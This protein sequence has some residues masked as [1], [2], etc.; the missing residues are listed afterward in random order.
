[1]LQSLPTDAPRRELRID[2]LREHAIVLAGVAAVAVVL[3]RSVPVGGTF[4]AKVM[5]IALTGGTLTVSLALR[6]LRAERFGVANRVTLVRGGLL[7][8]LAACIGEPASGWLVVAAAA[9]ALALDGV[10]GW[11][12]RRD[13][14]ASAFGA[15]FDME[16]DALS[17]LVLTLL[18][19]QLGKAGVWIL[20]AGL[21]RYAFVALAWFAPRF[22]RPLPERLR[23]KSA[24][25][26]TFVLLIVAAAPIVTVPLASI[27]AVV[28]LMLLTTSFAIDTL[29]LVRYRG[30][31]DQ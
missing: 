16:T 4:V 29:Y 14:S 7:A 11:L 2:V 9:T 30:G 23:R 31:P 12:A 28:A 10:D 8:V 22:D 24:F 19:W 26:I 27:C 1:M 17:L 5:L 6:Y 20:L 25:V 13:G 21:L 15:R 3:E 18:V